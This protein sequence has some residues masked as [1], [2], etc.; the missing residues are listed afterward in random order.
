MY[1]NHANTLLASILALAIVS[2]AQGQVPSNLPDPG[3]V[4]QYDLGIVAPAEVERRIPDGQ[5][6]ILIVYSAKWCAPCRAM[7]PTWKRLRDQGYQIVY[8]DVDHPDAY[9]GLY[10]YAT[11]EL[12]DSA[13]ED[14]PSSVPTVRWY[15]SEQDVEVRPSH[16]GTITESQVK[17][18]LWNPSSSRGLVQEPSQS[19]YAPPQLWHGLDVSRGYRKSSNALYVPAF[20]FHLRSTDR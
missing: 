8:I 20:G 6:D 10:P 9:V 16:S 19:S 18:S 7:V 12:I 4:A 3:Q 2:T 17:E 11:Q 15:N 5:A 13:M 1:M 14:A